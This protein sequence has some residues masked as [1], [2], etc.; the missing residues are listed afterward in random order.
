MHRVFA[1]TIAAALSSGPAVHAQEP[2]NVVATIGMIGNIAE[3]L[4]GDCVSVTTLMGPGIDPHLYQ[5]TARD[6]QTLNS[7]DLILYSGY[8]LEGQLGDVLARFAERIPTLA[9]AQAS[10]S[11]DEVIETSGNYNVDP[12]V[13]M[14][15][16]LWAQTVPSSPTRS[17]HLPPPAPIRSL[18]NNRHCSTSS[19]RFIHG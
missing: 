17:Q 18:S 13:W 14:D 1:L 4:G 8:G 7:A 16:R 9:V 5:A 10:I 2:L 19:T 6:V 3:T 12:H 15:A 11:A